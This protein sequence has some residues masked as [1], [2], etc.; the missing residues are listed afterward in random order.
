MKRFTEASALKIMRDN[1]VGIVDDTVLLI[2]KNGLKGIRSCAA[3]DFLVNHKR[4]RA[5]V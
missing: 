2:S 1:D 3:L 4:Y 5:Y